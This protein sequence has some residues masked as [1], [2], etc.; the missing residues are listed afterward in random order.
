MN[1]TTP[2]SAKLPLSEHERQIFRIF[3]ESFP[4]S[5]GSSGLQARLLSFSYRSL[6]TFED[7]QKYIE[8]IPKI[9]DRIPNLQV[10]KGHDPLA[11]DERL[12]EFSR[13]WR[14]FNI[15]FGM[16]NPPGLEESIYFQNFNRMDE[17]LL[18]YEIVY[19]SVDRDA[20]FVEGE[21]SSKL[22]PDDRYRSLIHDYAISGRKIGVKTYDNL[23]KMMGEFITGSQ[24]GSVPDNMPRYLLEGVQEN[25]SILSYTWNIR[26]LGK[27]FFTPD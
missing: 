18:F 26:N 22:S 25:L 2:E 12:D 23:Y 5:Q 27:D 14:I 1:N 8:A 7:F 20:H 13:M 21:R 16:Q 17:D 3:Y 15:I 6:L 10:P 19:H 24:S 9:A 11:S 4:L